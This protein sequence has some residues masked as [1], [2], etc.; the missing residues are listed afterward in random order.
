MLQR[1]ASQAR[2]RSPKPAAPK[3][4]PR[5]PPLRGSLDT[6]LMFVRRA[7]QRSPLD[8]SGL[9]PKVQSNRRVPPGVGS[10]IMPI[11]P[12]RSETVSAVG[13]IGGKT[14]YQTSFATKKRY[15]D[16]YAA[17]R[18]TRRMCPRTRIHPAI[19]DPAIQ[20]EIAGDVFFSLTAP[21][22]LRR[23][24]STMRPQGRKG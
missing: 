1:R 21:L 15:D 3:V 13:H 16:S 11:G 20:T 12:A 5:P 10:S 17:C 22:P 2:P 18:S 14:T 7:L 6:P 23:T 24:T 9:V 19:V 8:R 4:P